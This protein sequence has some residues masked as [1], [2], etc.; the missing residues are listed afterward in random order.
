M[1]LLWLIRSRNPWHIQ[2]LSK[3]QAVKDAQQALVDRGYQ[4]GTAGMYRLPGR[5]FQNRLRRLGIQLSAESRWHRGPA[6]LGQV[7]S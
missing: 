2:P 5:P 6:D 1:S 4:V 3:G 7:T